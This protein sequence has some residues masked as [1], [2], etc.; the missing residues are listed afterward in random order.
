MIKKIAIAALLWA[1]AAPIIMAVRPAPA[2]TDDVWKDVGSTIFDCRDVLVEH[3]H[4]SEFREL[5]D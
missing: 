5:S 2:Q 1:I 4:L 3:V